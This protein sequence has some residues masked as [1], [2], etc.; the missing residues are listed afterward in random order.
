MLEK[1]YK[2]VRSKSDKLSL[3]V[4]EKLQEKSQIE[5]NI[6][7]QKKEFAEQ[8]RRL[9]ENER[10]KTEGLAIIEKQRRL[11][12]M[13][14]RRIMSREEEKTNMLMGSRV[15]QKQLEDLEKTEKSLEKQISAAENKNSEHK[16]RIK[17]TRSLKQA[18]EAQC[19]ERQDEINEL[20]E[21]RQTLESD[22][23]K[24]EQ[25]VATL[26]SKED[27]LKAEMA[28]LNQE[29]AQL[30]ETVFRLER[31]EDELENLRQE[32]EKE[33]KE[34]V[35]E[36][37]M[38]QDGTNKAE[39][40]KKEQVEEQ[41]KLQKEVALLENLYK[42][43]SKQIES[44]DKE[45]R[46]L[47]RERDGKSREKAEL[48]AKC[49]ELEEKLGVREETVIQHQNSN[50]ELKT[51]KRHQQILFESVKSDRLAYSKQLKD[52][53]EEVQ[54]L[55]RKHKVMLQQISHVKEEIDFKEQRLV[56]EYIKSKDLEKNC[57]A[58]VKIQELLRN[59]FEKKKG[60]L[61]ELVERIE[62]LKNTIRVLGL[63]KTKITDQLGL[64]LG[65]R[66]ILSIQ[67]INRQEE[68][69]R[70]YE[71][72]EIQKSILVKSREQFRGRVV[73][74]KEL[75]KN[76]KYLVSK[77]AG[78]KDEAK[79]VPELFRDVNALEKEFFS[80]K[81]K[82]RVLLEELQCPINVHKWRKLES[83]DGKLYEMISKIHALQKRLILKGKE[84]K[85]KDEIL[86]HQERILH[87]LAVYMSRQ[88]SDYEVEMISRLEDIFGQKLEQISMLQGQIEVY[89][90]DCEQAQLEVSVKKKTLDNLKSKIAQVKR[91]AV[92]NTRH[93][94]QSLEGN[95]A[96]VTNVNGGKRNFRKKGRLPEIG[97]ENLIGV[98]GI[99]VMG[100]GFKM[101]KLEKTKFGKTQDGQNGLFDVISRNNNSIV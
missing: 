52:T 88:P 100:G 101:T 78:V 39:R 62:E 73:E 12:D 77:I 9:L 22:L 23:L 26:R 43:Y 17:D 13:L 48:Q 36:C 89:K 37:D 42:S 38:L 97:K 59:D 46:A 94:S 96:A 28:D 65:E 61:K 15:Q 60:N 25:E 81:L 44:G 5:A 68:L 4:K 64:I 34:L 49:E 95:L 84:S 58:L 74:K 53:Q 63:Q 10:N 29:I 50:A 20:A 54:E 91:R 18:L 35:R 79:K 86:S 93:S 31:E 19:G 21:E 71:K 70:L 27:T 40:N 32:E 57:E 92:Y 72:L 51:R 47:E 24:E 11:I 99:K 16:R 80:E 75:K 67:V 2:E 90:S 55:R 41:F 33:V 8:Q 14:K 76:A 1:D 3:E 7:H 30:K 87:E 82:T 66:D 69:K 83:T 98:N 45:L 56:K 6:L 85:E